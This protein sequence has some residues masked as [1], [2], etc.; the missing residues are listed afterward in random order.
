MSKETVTVSDSADT[1]INAAIQK[2]I[3]WGFWLAI[4]WVI[5]ITLLAILAPYLDLK[6]PRGYFINL[7]GN[8][9]PP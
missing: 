5:F 3:G 2:K 1:E 8:G 6:D 9:R 7:D 4:S